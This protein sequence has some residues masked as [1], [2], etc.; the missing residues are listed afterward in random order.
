MNFRRVLRILGS[1]LL[2][3]AGA[4]LVPLIWC[5]EPGAAGAIRG[6]VAGAAITALSGVALRQFGSV[7]GELYR[8]EGVLIV[9]G[10]WVLASLSGAIPY[11]ATGAISSPVDALFESASGFVSPSMKKRLA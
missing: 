8:R 2:V 6:F 7:S 4:Q 3:L 1:M 9:V 11:L 5:F 10:A